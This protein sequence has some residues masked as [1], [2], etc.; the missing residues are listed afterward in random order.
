M[1]WQDSPPRKHTDPVI[2]KGY[3]LNHEEIVLL[4]ELK[5]SKERGSASLG[6]S[7]HRLAPIASLERMGLARQHG[8][9]PTSFYITDAGMKETAKHNRL[10]EARKEEQQRSIELTIKQAE[11]QRQE[12]KEA[13][14]LYQP[15]KTKV[16]RAVKSNPN[17]SAIS[18]ECG[19][20]SN[21]RTKA[22]DFLSS[23]P[24]KLQTVAATMKVV[25]DG[26]GSPGSLD[27]VIR[28]LQIDLSKSAARDRYEIR[29]TKDA[30]GAYAYGFYKK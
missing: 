8:F 9:G 18:I 1:A 15:P 23:K 4:L 29:R 30:K 14:R 7:H 17:L 25:Y 12:K 24:G 11:K 22:L 28:A 2:E 26:N 13:A 19:V 16:Q 3:K 10:Y 21:Y 20:T 5:E 6:C 27:T